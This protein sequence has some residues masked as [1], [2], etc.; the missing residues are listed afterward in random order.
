MIGKSEKISIL[1]RKYEVNIIHFE[2]SPKLFLVSDFFG[3]APRVRQEGV[4]FS[5]PSYWWLY[6]PTYIYIPYLALYDVHLC[7]RFHIPD[8]M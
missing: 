1:Y 7:P 6:I 3:S 4:P 5:Q 8:F 2:A